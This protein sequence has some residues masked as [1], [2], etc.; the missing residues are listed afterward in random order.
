[1]KN[2]YFCLALCL[3]PMFCL[4]QWLETTIYLPDSLGGMSYPRAIAWNPMNNQARVAPASSPRQE[5][6]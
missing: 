2:K 6:A 3:A 1:M 4:A 5:V